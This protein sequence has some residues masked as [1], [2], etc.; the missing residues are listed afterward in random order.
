MTDTADVTSLFGGTDRITYRT[1]EPE[2]EPKQRW[3]LRKRSHCEQSSEPRTPRSFAELPSTVLELTGVTAVSTG[4]YQI[5]APVGWIG[6]GLMLIAMG[7]ATSPRTS[8]A[9]AA[10]KA[11][12]KSA[13]ARMKVQP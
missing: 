10:R 9:L 2:P 12:R 13:A 11:S 4:L 1:P 6:T 5:A 8:F 3:W 7:V